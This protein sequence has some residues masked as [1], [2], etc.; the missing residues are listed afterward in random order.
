MFCTE[1][2]MKKAYRRG[3]A[4]VQR[5]GIRNGGSGYHENRNMYG[6]IIQGTA[7]LKRQLKTHYF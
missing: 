5:K 4:N 6:Y 7:V 3:M 2:A 1:L